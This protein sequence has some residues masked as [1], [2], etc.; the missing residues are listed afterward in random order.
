MTLINKIGKFLP[1]LSVIFFGLYSFICHDIECSWWH[2]S[3]TEFETWLYRWVIFW[4][5]CASQRYFRPHINEIILRTLQH[6]QTLIS[7]LTISKVLVSR[8]VLDRQGLVLHPRWQFQ[9]CSRK[10]AQS[11]LP[12]CSINDQSLVLLMYGCCEDWLTLSTLCET[13]CGAHLTELGCCVGQR[14]ISNRPF[15]L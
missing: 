11:E 9:S 8:C 2:S 14:V 15:P 12:I 7:A 1:L 5:T 13:T 10:F 4:K 3:F 6:I